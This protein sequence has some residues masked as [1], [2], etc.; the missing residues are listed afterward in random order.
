MSTSNPQRGR[1]KLTSAGLLLV[2]LV[3]TA[4]TGPRADDGP[5]RNALFEVAVTA[6]SLPAALRL[7]TEVLLTAMASHPH[8]QNGR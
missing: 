2:L 8:G 5:D 4:R 3:S 7:F 6:A 1:G